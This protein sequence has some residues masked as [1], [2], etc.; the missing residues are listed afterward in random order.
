VLSIQTAR[1]LHFLVLVWFLFFIVIHVAL[2]L[3]TGAL[4]NLNHLYAA[5]DGD[6]WT[7]G[8]IFA[9]SIAVLIVAWVTATP[10]TLRHPRTV[11]RV[12]FALIGPVQRMFEH[13]D[14]SRRVHRKGHFALLLAQ[15]QV[16]RLS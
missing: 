13:V 4:R 16:P 10:F 15:R 1:S 6:S 14:H 9:V 7:G 11:Q 12:G 2:A 3:S 5:Q 8:A